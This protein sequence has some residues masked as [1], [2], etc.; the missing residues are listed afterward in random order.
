MP[1]VYPNERPLFRLLLGFS[2]LFWLGLVV[3][4]FGI[5]LLYAPLFFVG[6][7]FAQSGFISMLRGQGVRVSRSQLPDLQERL[8]R[9]CRRL[10]IDEVPDAYVLNA[11]GLL[12]ALA[13]RFLR[14]H[15][16]VLFS[17]VV[18]A[19]ADRPDA[20][21]FY[22]GH[23]L[24][25]I[26]R[27]HLAWGWFLAPAGVLPV[28]GAA[29]SRAREY[30]CDLHGLV[31]CDDP[32]DAAVGLAVLAAGERSLEQLDL[33]GYA[34]Q[35]EETG[36]FWMSYHELTADYP[37][38]TKRMRRLIAHASG[39][40]ATFPSRHPLAFGLALLVPRVGLPGTGGGMAGLLAMVAIVGVLAAVAIPN[41]V[42]FQA[43][44]KLAEVQQTRA[45]LQEA[46]TRYIEATDHMPGGLEDLGLPADLSG[47][48]VAGVEVAGDHFVIHLSDAVEALSGEQVV[49][50]PYV[51]EGR[52]VWDCQSTLAEELAAEACAL[53]APPPAAPAVEPAGI[54]G[55]VVGDEKRYCA[56]DWRLG[57]E[58]AALS[59]AQQAALREHCNAWRLRQVE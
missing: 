19:L 51:E 59:P 48:T 14:R 49:L 23:E 55:R 34:S 29:Y 37:W 21:D 10:E 42:R 30:S 27:G 56:A 46:A 50:T 40:P 22:I 16:V 33:Q 11:H 15:Y 2:C 5:A 44:A 31:C 52:L 3:G 7:L 17:D 26:K 24:G 13:T 39:Q 45:T 54:A 1:L 43:R 12:N 6:Y 36:G 18:D 57:D 20:L 53:G 4:T 38:L 28:L 9:C 8:E 58:Y 47:D 35:S 32:R 25:H 41:F